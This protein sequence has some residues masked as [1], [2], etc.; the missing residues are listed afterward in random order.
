MKRLLIVLTALL[1]TLTACSSDEEAVY[2]DVETSVVDMSGYA[3]MPVVGHNFVG[4]SPQE[5]LRIIEEGGS[6]A[7]FYGYS[8]CPFCHQAAY[9]LNNAAK[10]KDMTIY[11][12]NVHPSDDPG[13]DFYDA[14]DE[15]TTVLADFLSK[16][17]DGEPEFYVPNLFIIKN[18]KILGNHVSLVDSY[19][20]GGVSLTMAEENELF[21][22]YTD[23]LDKLD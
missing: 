22:I 1:L 23:L 4:V 19:P 12:V 3:N 16:D 6:G 9:V 15:T 17:E 18:G 20:G 10:E 21:N 14:M 2:I 13:D 5:V 8:T 7:V 11:Y